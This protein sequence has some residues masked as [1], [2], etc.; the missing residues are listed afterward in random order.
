MAAVVV[1]AAAAAA[2]ASGSTLVV[3]CA[4][5]VVG[6][7]SAGTAGG[8]CDPCNNEGGPPGMEGGFLE[9][10]EGFVAAGCGAK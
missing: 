8:R 10:V 1:A 2:V 6:I 3:A 7:S 5:D 4:V 9:E